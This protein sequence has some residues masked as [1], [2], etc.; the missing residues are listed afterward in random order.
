MRKN[1]GFTLVE[2]MVAVAILAIASVAVLRYFS[3]SLYSL[4]KSSASTRYSYNLKF[5]FTE[6]I[7]K[8]NL[9]ITAEDYDDSDSYTFEDSR[10][11]Y[12]FE[13]EKAPFVEDYDVRLIGIDALKINITVKDKNTG[14]SVYKG[15]AYHLFE[16]KK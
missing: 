7:R 15:E 10:F 9:P 3:Q 16:T 14:K 4:G 8:K 1:A 6:A 2:I 11:R 5:Y 12:I 13:F